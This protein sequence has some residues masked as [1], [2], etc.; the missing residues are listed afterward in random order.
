MSIT[1]GSA[2]I[3]ENGNISGGRAGDQTGN[4][5]SMQGYYMHSQGWYCLR[6]RDPNVANK[7][8]QSMIDACNNNYIGYDQ[9]NRNVVSV[10]KRY[11]S[12]RSIREYC[13]TDCANLVRGCI[14]EAT[15]RDLGDFYTG[16]EAAV[17][18]SSG[19]FESRFNVSSSSQL[20]N[21]DVLVTKSKGHTVVVVSGR[22]RSGSS[23]GGS[24]GGGSSSGNTS[25]CG[26]G[27]GTAVCTADGVRIRTGAGTNYTILGSVNTG[28]AV[29]VL[30]KTSNWYKIVWPG[31]SIGYAYTC[32]DY[33]NYT[34][35]V[36][37]GTGSSSSIT[38][39]TYTVK[40][41]DTLS[42]IAQMMGV[43]TNELAAYNG[44]SNPNVISV[45]QVIKNPKFT[46]DDYIVQKGDTLSEIA[47]R[48][49]VSTSELA[50]YNGIANPNNIYV[51]QV[52]HK[53]SSSGSSS[54]ADQSLVKAGQIH[55]NNFVGAGLTVDGNRGTAT[56]QAGVKCLQHALNLDFGENLAVDGSWGNATD[57][58]MKKYSV[59][60]GDNCYTVTALQILLLLKDYNP[61]GVECPGSFGDGCKSAVESYQSNNSLER[62]GI[63][64]YNTF[65][66]LCN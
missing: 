30:S 14:W 34:A 11:G 62:D 48:M 37:S 16:N 64:G 22:P 40:S 50:A 53:P 43:S 6:P 26:Q 57:A 23:T 3:D 12:M 25:Y 29:E 35:N 21:G 10:V 46:G 8:A 52:I 49:G 56:K 2:R 65:R 4:E 47:Q 9:S 28:T 38:G 32:S 31:A 18:E 60:P 5:V 59:K 7:I 63:A 20:Y 44:I 55:A 58:A 36:S 13:E 15:G 42:E 41:G 19:L 33:Y 66:S 24:S 51:G 45:G 27:I 39:Q 54:S 17:L 1:F 61:N